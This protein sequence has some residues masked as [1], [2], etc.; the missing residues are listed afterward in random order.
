MRGAQVLVLGCSPA[1]SCASQSSH[2]VA[3][4]FASVVLCQQAGQRVQAWL[5]G[6]MAE[7]GGWS[8]GGGAVTASGGPRPSLEDVGAEM[9]FEKVLT[10]CDAASRG[11]IVLPKVRVLYG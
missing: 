2:A 3:S 9:L 4:P 8:A 6:R 5:D 10:T 7:A 1:P 11:R